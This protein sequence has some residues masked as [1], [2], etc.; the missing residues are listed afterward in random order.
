M[1]TNL[2]K[3]YYK[4]AEEL[5]ELVTR[6]LQQA[7]KHPK[8]DYEEKILQELEDVRNYVRKLEKLLK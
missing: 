3:A 8:K 4:L 1:N 2:R 7:N 5:S 6:V